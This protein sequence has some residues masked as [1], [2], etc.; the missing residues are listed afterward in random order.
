MLKK[1]LVLLFALSASFVAA[2]GN[3]ERGAELAQTCAACHGA[4]GNSLVGSFP[5]IA[6]QGERYFIEQLTAYRDGTR[7]NALMQG[8]VAALSEQDFAD[9][10][11]F[12]A[13]QEPTF[14]AADPDLVAL[15]QEIYRA[16]LIDSGVMACMAC[17]GAQGQGNAPAG[18]PRV[19][20]QHAEYTIAQLKA[21]RA[22]YLATEASENARMTDGQTM[23]RRAVAYRLRDHEIEAL[24]SY[25]EGLH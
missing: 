21:Y 20:G 24:A 22:G 2:Q 10:A 23:M 3:V 5:S 25:L 8:Q 19:A 4:D 1:S 18:F 6:G 7:V 9:L 17:H 14:G 12:Y 16:G 11:A 13:V 15:G